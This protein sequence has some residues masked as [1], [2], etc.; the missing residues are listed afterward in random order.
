MAALAASGATSV[1]GTD[2][3]GSVQ[4]AAEP[5][6]VSDFELTDHEGKLFRS[7]HLRGRDVLVFFGFTKCPSICPAALTRLQL[8]TSQLE[9]DGE[10]APV[11]VLI[12]VDG[13]RDT[14]A[15]LTDYLSAFPPNFIGLTGDPT[16][17]RDIAA[18]FK[19]VFFKGL[20][21]DKA[22]NYQVEHTSMIY[23]LD[24]NGR[25]RA[26]FMDAPVEVM[27]NTVRGLGNRL[28]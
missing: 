16:S 28:E 22:G 26:T 4:I 6:A 14:P 27:A 5:S 2:R 3:T 17:V 13:E 9:Q 7:P 25:L 11:V 18:R 19:A 10:A 23:L 8:L 20:P 21:Y 12:S 1:A 24:A 15:V